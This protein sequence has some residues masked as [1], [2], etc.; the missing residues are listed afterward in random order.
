M[1]LTQGFRL[2]KT[3]VAALAVVGVVALVAVLAGSGV[4]QPVIERWQGHTEK[5]ADED[6]AETPEGHMLVRDA[7]GRPVNP[8]TLRLTE[9]AARGLE[10]APRTIVAAKPATEPR[11]LPS[12]SGS[13]AY[14]NDALYS[15][16]PRFAGEVVA[17]GQVRRESL[18]ETTEPTA[19][20]QQGQSRWK[21]TRALGFGDHVKKGELLAV[22]WSRDL[23]D[24]KAALI[25]ASIDLRR[26]RKRLKDLEAGY[27]ATAISASTY[28][29]AQ[30]TVQKDIS[31]ANAAERTLRM[32]KL[33]DPE[34]DALKEEAAH[35]DQSKR[36]P[37][38]EMEWARVEVRAPH[39]GVLVEKNT[40]VGD[41]V[42]PSRDTP[43]FR[44][45]D[46]RRLAVWANAMEEYRPTIQK[47]MD[48]GRAK[49]LFWQV[50]LNAEPQS[51]P[52][53]GPV[54][55]IAP[56]LDPV[57][58][59]LL[60]IGSVD[61]PG[62]RLIVG[63]MISATIFVRPE[64]GLVEIPTDALNE[65]NGQSIVFVQPDPNK[66]EFA[67]RRVAVSDRFQDVVFVRS[68][69]TPLDEYESRQGRERGLRPIEPLR[70]G[71]RVITRGVTM[72]TVA[73]R[74]LLSKGDQVSTASK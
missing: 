51:P 42:D 8:P 33:T 70:P 59:T 71:E 27:R 39:D 52:L 29:E 58:R 1:K 30:R 41:M 65:Q 15:V 46:L 32:W 66:L 47:L 45:A 24:K 37:K 54:L 38:K 64:P 63:Q 13:L 34:I 7:D 17:L 72:M 5:Q 56:S 73:L 16:R 61:N 74:D 23:G 4:V 9:E 44:I 40:N 62:G 3:A 20:A 55:R 68:K 50:R 31:A 67:L 26:D 22:V 14:E 35:I 48:E 6:K 10:I 2:P 69:L 49:H 53:E 57:Q 36:D 11:P 28:Y 60:V 21:E 19:S 43:M 25:D 18:E 12:L